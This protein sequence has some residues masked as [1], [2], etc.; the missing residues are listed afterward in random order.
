MGS[1]TFQFV[2]QAHTLAEQ[3]PQLTSK[4]FDMAAFTIDY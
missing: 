2:A 1:K 4:S 3:N